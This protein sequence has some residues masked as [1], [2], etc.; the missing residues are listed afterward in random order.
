[1][2]RFELNRNP[3]SAIK[4]GQYPPECHENYRIYPNDLSPVS[5]GSAC[6]EISTHNG[7][8]EITEV[9]VKILIIEINE[10]RS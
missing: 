2:L 4:G 5:G 6:A 9:T 1:M 7:S 3:F 8:V 10:K